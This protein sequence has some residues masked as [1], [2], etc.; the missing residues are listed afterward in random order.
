MSEL[1]S[2]AAVPVIPADPESL[3]SAAEALAS[4]ARTVDDHT[5]A[6]ASEWSSLSGVYY[7]PD[8]S[9]LASKINVVRDAGTDF[10]ESFAAAATA[11]GDLAEALALAKSTADTV[12]AEVPQLRSQVLSYRR[13]QDELNETEGSQAWGPGQYEWNA[14]LWADCVTVQTGIDSAVD[15]CEAALGRIGPVPFRASTTLVGSNLPVL[16]GT[17]VDQQATFESALGLALLRRL[18]ADG[19]ADAA[20]LLEDHPDW[21]ALLQDVPP[22][23]EDVRAWWTGLDPSVTAALV[24]GVPILIGNLDGVRLTDRFTANR[25]NVTTAIDDAVAEIERLEALKSSV[26]GEPGL[27]GEYARLIEEQQAHIDAW[28]ALLEQN[29][30]L[31]DE[32]GVPYMQTGPN[33]AVFD[34]DRDAIATYHGPID[35]ATGDIPAW[36]ENVVVSVPGTGANITDWAD[37]RGRDI[38]NGD[39]EYRTAVFQWAGG[40]F[41]QS[42]PEAMDASYS[43]ALA[44]R[45]VSFT[46]GVPVPEGADLTVLGHSYG[47]ATVGV[48]EAEGLRADKVLYVAAAGLG[49]GNQSLDDFPHTS[50]VPHYAIMARNDMVVGPIQSEAMDWMHG[51]STLD[52]PGVTRL[53]TGAIRAD[54][55][56]SEWIEQ[57][58]VPGNWTPPAIDAHSTVFYPASQSFANI[59]AV[60]TGGEATVFAP[61]VHQ[62]ILGKRYTSPA[63]ED[64]DHAPEYVTIE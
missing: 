33:I 29:T 48:A 14:R 38:Y 60:I 44:P 32:N 57:Y 40:A 26:G 27:E 9:T 61:D 64:P 20:S 63:Y 3:A 30:K 19:G 23:A 25:T 12:R 34:P 15:I 16:P 51:A 59:M 5:D 24:A 7:T 39:T 4:Q 45:L 50:D 22:P 37:S 52:I 1:I 31:F 47:G 18:S 41:P 17:A 28:R 2:L 46:S 62:T 49:N 8:T 13:D 11:L 36:I 21:L 10:A 56:D 58:N 42:I 53:D 6:A 55:P 35:P 43:E 54:D